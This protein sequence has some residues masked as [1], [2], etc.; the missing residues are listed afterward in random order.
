M[1]NE[2][3]SDLANAS[4]FV[5]WLVVKMYTPRYLWQLCGC[6]VFWLVGNR[7]VPE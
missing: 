4:V 2:R 6:T 5:A 7:G 1:K 3:I